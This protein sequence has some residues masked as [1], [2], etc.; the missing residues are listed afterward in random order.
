MSRSRDLNPL[1]NVTRGLTAMAIVW[2]GFSVLPSSNFWPTADQPPVL[3]IL[4]AAVLITWVGVI[5]ACAW[6]SLSPRA[7]RLIQAGNIAALFLAGFVEIVLAD[8]Q[9]PSPLAEPWQPGASLIN[10]GAA[11]TGLLLARRLAVPIVTAAVVLE[12]LLIIGQGAGNFVATDALYPLYAAAVG[13]AAIGGRHGLVNAAGRAEAARGALSDA[14]TEAEAARQVGATL[15]QQER[16]LHEGVLNTLTAIARGGF[17]SD[18]WSLARIR[19]RAGQSAV[20]LRDLVG[21]DSPD[22]PHL[23]G[24]WDVD[25]GPMIDRLSAQG[26][27][28]SVEF[29]ASVQL[30][31][32]IYRTFIIAIR[33]ALANVERHADA[34]LATIKIDREPGRLRRTTAVIQ[35]DG[36]GFDSQAIGQRFGLDQSIDRGLAEIGGSARVATAPGGG[37]TVTMTWTPPKGRKSSEPIPASTAAFARPVLAWF[38]IFTLVSFALTVGTVA[39][40]VLDFTA[41]ALVLAVGGLF[42]WR[43]GSSGLPSRLVLL[44]CVVAPIAYRL[45][46]LA[47]GSSP[48]SHWAEWSS[49]AIA[50]LMVVVAAVGPWWSPVAAIASWLVT[51]GDPLHELLQPGSAVILAGAIFAR[52]VRR[53]TRYLNEYTERKAHEVA[54]SLAAQEAIIRTRRRY[55]VLQESDA[56]ALLEGIANGEV[57]PLRDE[58]RAKCALEEQFIRSVMRLDPVVDQV[59]ALAAVMAAQARGRG[60]ALEIDLRDTSG[61]V[62]EDFTGFFRAVTKGLECA[63]SGEVA[64]LTSRREG[65]SVVLR[66]VVHTDVS[67]CPYPEFLEVGPT[68]TIHLDRVDGLLLCEAHH[69]CEA[70][71]G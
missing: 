54:A 23:T 35:D 33:E 32:G 26:C 52:S 41:L 42:Y 68:W 24:K 1:G 31:A 29:N 66:F 65:D 63:R 46:N 56:V 28:V 12:S 62:P 58:V 16:A 34:S 5:G 17:P 57:D 4:L 47:A 69:S 15:A 40:P 49:E 48:Q 6:P 8:V 71:H 13:A 50:A 45:D 59:H 19:G 20:A 70:H 64:R 25:L 14:A 67:Q 3:R 37:T 39:L 55:A 27:R 60:L 38:G 22:S 61:I 43:S 36:R 10:V 30:P 44:A 18:G 7:A 51:Q 21:G 2:E 53:N 9:V 11:V